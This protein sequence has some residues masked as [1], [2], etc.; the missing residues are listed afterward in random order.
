M[1]RSNII[2]A[3]K[4]DH[5]LKPGELTAAHNSAANGFYLSSR[6]LVHQAFLDKVFNKNYVV[7]A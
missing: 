1:L 7:K 6:N 4:I 3:T 2:K 5:L